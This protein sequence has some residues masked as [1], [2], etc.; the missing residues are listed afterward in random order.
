M[1]YDSSKENFRV[2]LAG[3]CMLTRRLSVFDEPA[4]LALRDLFRGCDAGFVNLESVVRRPDEGTPGVTRGTYM[5]TPPELLSDLSWLGVTMVGNA[6]NHAYDYGEAGL[7][8]TIRH[9]TEAGIMFAGIG[10]NL[11]EARRP[12]YLDTRAG[13]VA[14]IATT[15]TYRPWNAASPQ[16]PDM[17]GRPGI[18]PLGSTTTYTV[19]DATFQAL[20]KMSE[21]LGFNQT[22]KRNRT[23][24]F[25][26]K[27][28][29]PDAQGEMQL[30]G[31]RIVKGSKFCTA[32]S[33]D[34]ADIEDNLRWVREARRQAD[35]VLV[36]FHSHAFAHKSV[37]S[38]ATK[39]DL[40]EPADFVPD[41][42]R[43]AIDA[44]ADIF[45]G[46][47]SHTPLGIEI[48]KGKPILYSV[49]NFIFQNESVRSFPAEAYAR[50]GLGHDAT[51]TDFLDARTGGGSKGHIAHMGFWE[52]IVVTCEFRGGKGAEIRIHPIEQGFGASLGQR[53]RPMLATG[54]IANRVIDRVAD[55]SRTYGVEV[56]NDKGI[57]V[58]TIGDKR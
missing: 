50:F 19:D 32:S 51:P 10:Q 23:H 25:N 7:T 58:I 39:I 2:A 53:G 35:W 47:G 34:N 37:A 41:F 13:R 45:V 55:L 4:F 15:A 24:F 22:R 56:R 42:A 30:F 36:S 52:N 31:E 6:N 48:Y 14:L 11:A 54:E 17:R 44:G 27:E 16:R 18:N 49:G 33:A 5:T 46:H 8:A 21:G 26:D 12:G 9:L 57:G 1:G 40:K 20:D 43:A 28:A 3:D 38:A 29:P